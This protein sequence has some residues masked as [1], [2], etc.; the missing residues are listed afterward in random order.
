M[1]E[2]SCFNMFRSIAE[3]AAVFLGYNGWG[4]LFKDYGENARKFIQV[5]NMNS[6]E[7]YSETEMNILTDEQAEIFRDGFNWFV[8]KYKFNI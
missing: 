4:E 2:K 3:K 5:V 1:L 7:R 6:H 8:K